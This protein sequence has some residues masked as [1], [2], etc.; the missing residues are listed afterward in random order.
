MP[1][2][3]HLQ[4]LIDSA[5][6]LKAAIEAKQDEDTLVFL[7]QLR[8]SMGMGNLSNE[9]IVIRGEASRRL[10]HEPVRIDLYTLEPDD[11]RPWVQIL[12]DTD[13][14]IIGQG[15]LGKYW[16][17]FAAGTTETL[18]KIEAVPGKGVTWWLNETPPDL[19]EELE[20]EP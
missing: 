9:L 18:A 5:T 15:L 17:L 14:R 19:A 3:T 2:T 4:H 11:W 8:Q 6:R 16:N 1:E 10:G 20:D 13:G 7:R 12:E